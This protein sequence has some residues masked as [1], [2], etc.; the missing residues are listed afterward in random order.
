MPRPFVPLTREQFGDALT[1]FRWTRRVTS[2]H[3][4]HT[5]KPTR[6][7]WKGVRTVE[8]MYDFHVRENGWSDIAQHVT[9]AP[10][11]TIWTGRDW[12]APPASS[13]DRRGNN[14][15]VIEGPFMLEIVGNFDIGHDPFAGVQRAATLGVVVRVQRRF[16]LAPESLKFHRDLGSPKT[17]PGS[18]VV[19]GDVLAAVRREH[20]RLAAVV[21]AAPDPRDL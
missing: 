17:C 12:N 8:G 14:G 13:G 9:I 2:V 4:H 11:G 7:D 15:T 6:A 21:P 3:M 16:G 10:D 19:Y 20:V 5:W 1:R 18:G